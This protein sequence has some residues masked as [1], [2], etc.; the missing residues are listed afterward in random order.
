[1]VIMVMTDGDWRPTPGQ[2][3]TSADRR[4]TRDTGQRPCSSTSV[5]GARGWDGLHSIEIKPEDCDKT[6]FL[7]EQG[8]FASVF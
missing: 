6:M 4:W 1:M 7:G 5:T 2:M 8:C 3:E